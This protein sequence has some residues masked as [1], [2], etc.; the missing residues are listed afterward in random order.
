MEP[1]QLKLNTFEGPL[2]L[3]LHLT[4]KM[5]VNLNDI[6]IA[7]ITEQ[8]MD[9]IH[10]WQENK[11][12]VAGEYLVMA[13]TLMFIKSK[14]LLPTEIYGEELS[15]EEFKNLDPRA[16]LAR[17]LLEYRQFKN[18]ASAL[19]EFEKERSH[20]FTKEAANIDEYRDESPELPPNQYTIISLFLAFSDLLEKQKNQQPINITIETETFTIKEKMSQIIQQLE[21]TKKRGDSYLRFN[22]LF[23]EASSKA[24]IITTFLAVLELI[25]TKQLDIQQKTNYSP[26]EITW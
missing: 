5:E 25:K 17:Q 21:A 23:S 2:D 9:Y 24:E 15:E 3:L 22:E 7:E 6:P 10:S 19:Q 13:S 12:E 8:Y 11:L 1:I 20:Y 4:K 14:M 18:V 16:K 26:I